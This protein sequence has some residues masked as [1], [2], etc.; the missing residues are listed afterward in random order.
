MVA[1]PVSDELT[2]QL[3]V[4]E[5]EA[6]QTRA[7]IP[8]HITVRGTFYEPVNLR[9]V[10]ETVDRIASA[11]DRIILQSAGNE[12]YG[13]EK[14]AGFRF[15]P[16]NDIQSLHD[17]LVAAIE[18]VIKPAYVDDPFRCHLSIVD[19]IRPSG[20]ERAVELGRRIVL[21]G[22]LE[23]PFLDTYGRDGNATDGTWKRLSRIEL[24]KSQ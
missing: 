24:T 9:E 1:L 10:L 22:A 12:V 23:F 11:Y 21:P 19:T 14:S 3:S 20:V 8:S 4:I 18:P 2:N 13:T 6:G 5:K 15:I 17:Q 7:K 16:T